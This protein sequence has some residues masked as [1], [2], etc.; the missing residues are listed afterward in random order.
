MIVDNFSDATSTVHV[1]LIAPRYVTYGSTAVLH[2]N[3]SVPDA[4]L[5]KVE[6][7]KD[8]KTILRYIKDRKPPFLEWGVDG[9]NMEVSLM[10][11]TRAIS[12]F[13]LCLL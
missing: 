11:L 4:S 13:Q 3:H 10:Q 7:M 8:D 5:H 9:A 1:Q 12:V 6:F 2:C